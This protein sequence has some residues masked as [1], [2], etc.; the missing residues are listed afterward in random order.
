MN[1]TSLYVICTFAGLGMTGPAV[2]SDYSLS[3]GIANYDYGL[4]ITT[5][6]VSDFSFDGQ[7]YEISLQRSSSDSTLAI[8]HVFSDPIDVADPAEHQASAYG[9]TLFMSQSETSISLQRPLNQNVN[10]FAGYYQS[11]LDGKGHND[12]HDGTYF[13]KVHSWMKT[14][15]AFFGLAAQKQVSDKL[16]LFGRSAFQFVSADVALADDRRLDPDVNY[17]HA[18]TTSAYGIEGSAT[19]FGFGL[20]YPLDTGA[21]IVLGYEKKDF[22]FQNFNLN[23]TRSSVDADW[24]TIGLSISFSL[25]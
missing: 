1:K 12:G 20:A 7:Q 14:R 19:L 22:D 16:F 9:E 6:Q 23:T 8:K 3:V 10:W 2:S 25:E 11:Q 24:E 17:Q 21:T 15:G 13:N 5:G 4:K 18:I